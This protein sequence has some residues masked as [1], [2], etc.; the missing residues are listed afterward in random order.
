MG[1][2]IAHTLQLV[3]F[4]LLVL[5]GLVLLSIELFAWVVNPIDVPLAPMVGLGQETGAVTIGVEV[6]GAIHRFTGPLWGALLVVYGIYLVVTRKILVFEP[7]KKPMKQQIRE[8]IA[9]LNH[10]ALSK[11]L[12]KDVE[13]NLERH[14]VLVSYLTI[15]L[16]VAFILVEA[17]A[18]P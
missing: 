8:A 16:I 6:T 7:L 18:L 10:Y 4:T 11:P 9:L 5:T 3:F 2:R 13:E 15:V 17:A 14:N 1:T 12:P